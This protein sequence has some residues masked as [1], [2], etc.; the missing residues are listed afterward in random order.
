MWSSMLAGY[1]ISLL[2]FRY[3]LEH[4]SCSIISEKGTELNADRQNT[5]GKFTCLTCFEIP[6]GHGMFF[7]IV[8][9]YVIQNIACI[10]VV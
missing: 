1:S 3:V 7:C 2:T 5:F 10:N 4:E 8:R 6:K 9:Q